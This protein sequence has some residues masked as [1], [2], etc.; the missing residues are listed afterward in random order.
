[1]STNPA[2][3]HYR[4]KRPAWF[5]T[6]VFNRMLGLLTKAGLGVWGMH[7]L[8]VQGRRSGRARQTPVNV[9]EF[10]GSRYLVAPRGETEWV[11][12]LRAS[13]HGKLLLGRHVEDFTPVELTDAEKTPVLRAYLRRWRLEV[14]VFFD[15]L[16]PDAPDEEFSNAAARHPVFR[17]T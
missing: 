11:R 12:N 4:R 13:G 7:T 5:T 10:E 15:G 3:E 8:E 2:A 14:G 9:L 17:L 16:E 6:N 1:M